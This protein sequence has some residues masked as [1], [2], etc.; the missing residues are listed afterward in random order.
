MG[1]PI[2]AIASHP[3]NPR[4]RLEAIAGQAVSG[5]RTAGVVLGV[6]QAGAVYE[7]A[8]GFANLETLSPMR[9]ETVLR[10]GSLTK[11]FT[12][13]AI[14]L[15]KEQGRLG[16]EDNL[17]RFVPKFPRGN[18]VTIRQLL[19][20]T[21]GL[22]DFTHIK[23]FDDRE[24]R[25]PLDTAQMISLIAGQ[26]ELYDFAPGTAWRY[27]NSGYYM[28]GAVIEAVTGQPLADALRNLLFR[29]LGLSNTAV[30]RDGEIVPGRA[31]GYTRDRDSATGFR[32]ADFASAGPPG[33]AGAMRGNVG[34][35]LRWHEEL[36]AGRA[37]SPAG[38]AEMT[39]PGRLA[40][41]SNAIGNARPGQ[42]GYGFGL[43]MGVNAGRRW[44]GHNGAI[45]GFSASIKTYPQEKLTLVVLS[46][47]DGAADALLEALD[48]AFVPPRRVG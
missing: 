12:A 20:H 36:W 24:A 48:R 17:A 6:R 9:P 45:N 46:N 3:A 1:L 30:D 5:R 22:H 10:I 33:A 32:N 2:T 41:G 25:E 23:G 21:S 27:S 35:L 26:P 44:F 8:A 7:S 16:Y 47:T 4:R 37:I 34:N 11:Q 18:G 39:S 28:L 42:D 13:A 15:L 29:P 14:V 38:L 40:N 31:S 43:G 19:T